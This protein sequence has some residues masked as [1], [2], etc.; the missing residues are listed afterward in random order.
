VELRRPPPIVRLVL[1]RFEAVN[2]RLQS[3]K[4]RFQSFPTGVQKTTSLSN[5]PNWTAP[6]RME[7]FFQQCLSVLRH[8][9]QSYVTHEDMVDEKAR[10]HGG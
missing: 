10:G 9:F 5:R 3:D 6:T 7:T 8:N 2:R 4:K 1:S